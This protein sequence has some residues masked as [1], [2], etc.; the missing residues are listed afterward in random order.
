M[1]LEQ[2]DEIGADLPG[3]ADGTAQGC[4]GGLARMLCN[5]LPGLVSIWSGDGDRAHRISLDA[6]SAPAQATQ[7]QDVA[8]RDRRVE[9]LAVVGL[10]D[11]EADRVALTGSGAG[12]GHG[13]CANHQRTTAVSTKP[14]RILLIP[15][16]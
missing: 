4:D 5:D 9:P 2:H 15:V 12:S 10:R 13:R 7:L 1:H 11:D 3:G 8:G 16:I 14:R 6:G